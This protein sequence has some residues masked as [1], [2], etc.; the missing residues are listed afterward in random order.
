MMKMKDYMNRPRGRRRRGA[1]TLIELL[2]VIAIIALLIGVLLP[3]LGGAIGSARTLKCQTNMRSM[4]QAALSYGNDFRDTIPSFSWKPGNYESPY[5]DLQ[6]PARD[7][8]AI[9]YQAIHILREKTGNPYIPLSTGS[10]NNWYANLW[11]SHLT[12]LDYMTGNLEEPV[13]ACPQDQDQVD[14][15][16]IPAQDYEPRQ[17]YR[18]FESS[19]EQS[20]V[21]YSVDFERPGQVGPVVQ[22]G[23]WGTFTRPSNFLTLRRFNQVRFTSGKAFLFDTYDR[24]FADQPDTLYFQPGARQPI[25]FFDGSVSVRNTAES[26]QGFQPQNPTSP[27]P[28]SMRVTTR[29]QES[30]PG[31]YRWTR[32]GLGGIDYGGAEVNTGQPRP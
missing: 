9:R 23:S 16:E 26:N 4:G 30:Y 13:A 20:I 24:H 17:L 8:D 29:D 15:A 2:V 27:D 14:R 32:G 21:T 18:K 5:F 12:Y 3:A 25:L 10:G 22:G 31:Y 7:I 28:T 6:N 1:F 19:Y 11:F